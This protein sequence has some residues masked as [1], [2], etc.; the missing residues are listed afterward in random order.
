VLRFDPYAKYHMATGPG[1]GSFWPKASKTQKDAG[2]P[3]L[4]DSRNQVGPQ[5]DG[6]AWELELGGEGRGRCKPG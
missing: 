3:E 6:Y 5:P 2:G 1:G 4:T